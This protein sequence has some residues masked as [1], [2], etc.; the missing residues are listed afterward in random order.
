[1]LV[2]PPGR[3]STITCWPNTSSACSAIARAVKS[4]LPPAAY[5]TTMRTVRRD[6]SA[7]ARSRDAT[8][9]QH[10]RQDT[11]MNGVE[12]SWFLRC[13]EQAG[14][15]ARVL[16]TG[17][18]VYRACVSGDLQCRPD[19]SDLK[20]AMSWAG[21]PTGGRIH[22]RATIA[23]SEPLSKPS[24]VNDPRSR[25]G[26]HRAPFGHARRRGLPR[27]IDRPARAARFRV[28]A[29]Q[30]N[31]VTICGRGA[32]RAAPLVVLRRAYRRRAHRPA[33]AV[34]ERSVRCR[35][36]ATACSTAAARP[37]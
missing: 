34:A 20:R 21:A 22:A 29:H 10:A 2:A 18:S 30:R 37:T 26:A 32:G 23:E 3:F 35:P 1:M 14:E 28:R 33:R 25:P 13:G 5:G 11:A 19:V 24:E 36:S 9:V 4:V 12:A 6:S 15:R 8:L 17:D 7:Q 16:L 31:G 27:L